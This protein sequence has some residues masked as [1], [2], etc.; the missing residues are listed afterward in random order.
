M[1]RVLVLGG[2]GMLGHKLVQVFGHEFETFT[3][4]R[5]EFSSVK[6]F[7]IFEEAK[8]LAE[9]D[10]SDFVQLRH[11]L[12]IT[13]PDVVV[14]AVG[15]IKQVTMARDLDYMLRLNTELPAELS[16]LAGILDFRLVGISTDCVFSGAGGNYVEADESDAADDY[17]RSK[18]LGE[19]IGK[20][21]LTIRT[22]IIGRELDTAHSLIEW[23]LSNRGGTVN[24]YTRAIY[25]G[26]PTIVLAEILAMLIRD[27]PE[28][29]GLYHVSS[30]SISKFDLLRLINQAYEAK[31]EIIPDGKFSIDRSLDST[32]FREVTGFVPDSWPEM[33][34]RMAN[35]P[36]PYDAFHR[37][38]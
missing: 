37:F 22:S 19:A 5:R 23:F 36:T 12:E 25:T 33:I 24:G 10:A 34:L 8:T 15:V 2:S 11:V 26:F 20:N 6:R 7:G 28:L 35:D 27:H 32:R 4:I 17:G 9:V 18:H 13:D 3:T 31:I 1:K 38:A 14:N 16:R 29:T 30:Q 21:C